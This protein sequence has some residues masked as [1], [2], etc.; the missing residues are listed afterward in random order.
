VLDPAGITVSA[1]AGAQREPAV[2]WHGGAW[3]LVWTDGRATPATEGWGARLSPAG[4]VTL[5]ERRIGAGAAN[6]SSPALAARGDTLVAAWASV[7]T[8]A[9]DVR[10]GRL[11]VD[12]AAADDAG[13]FAVADGLREER[14]PAV[15][16][17]ERGCALYAY[18]R[19]DP[20]Q[21]YG[22]DRVRLR[23]ECYTPPVDAGVPDAG[24]ALDAVAADVVDATVAVD[25]PVVVDAPVV[26]DVSANPDVPAA[27]PDVPAVNTDVPA[28]NT[29]VPAVN[30]DVPAV[31]DAGAPSDVV[32][33]TGPK[34][35][36]PVCSCGVVGAGGSG[37]AATGWLLA[38]ALGAVR[39]RRRIAR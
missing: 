3:S 23:V 20:A 21:P 35:G 33:D 16:I 19:F 26:T 30:T 5:S 11:G 1:A 22:I 15:S 9:M 29:D 34:D 18:E 36:K 12:L 6:A 24:P 25:V 7:A 32:G 37:P 14:A 4:A 31:T 28:V 10:A 38:A 13:V 17:D 39:R 27:N 8:G 2:A